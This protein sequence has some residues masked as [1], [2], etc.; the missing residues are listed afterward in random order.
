MILIAQKILNK[1]MNRFRLCKPKDKC[2][3]NT[4]WGWW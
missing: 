2:C 3:R 1:N 4:K